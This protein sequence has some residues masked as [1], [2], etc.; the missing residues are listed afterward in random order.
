MTTDPELATFAG[1]CFWCTEAAFEEVPG[2]QSVTAGYAGGDVPD[3]SYEE[4]STGETGHAECVQIEYDPDTVSYVDLLGVFFRVHDPT[5]LN[6]QG[7][8]VGTQYRSAIFAHDMTQRETAA[9]FIE[10]LL[11]EDAY[12]E[13]IVTEIEDL[14]TFYPAEPY[15]QDYYEENPED[16]YC[17]LYVEPKVKKVQAAFSEE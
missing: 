1:G 10:I 13:E 16:R 4:V 2:V 6:R 7:P 8:D 17:T 15:H 3:P 5:Q 11:A 12:D 14:D 9:E